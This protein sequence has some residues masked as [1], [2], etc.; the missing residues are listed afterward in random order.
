MQY[1]VKVY[2]LHL[3]HKSLALYMIT[4]SNSNPLARYDGITKISL[5]YSSSSLTTILTLSLSFK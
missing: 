2:P 3:Y 1:K 5:T 4:A